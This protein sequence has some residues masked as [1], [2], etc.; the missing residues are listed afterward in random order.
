MRKV[1]GAAQKS[2]EKWGVEFYEKLYLYELDV[3]EKIL[4]RLTTPLAIF[5]SIAGGIL[6]MLRSYAKHGLNFPSVLFWVFFCISC[7][8]S[9]I[10]IFHLARAWWNNR[11]KIMPTAEKI[12]E[13]Y[14]DV[15]IPHYTPYPKH[16]ELANESF[17]S[18]LLDSYCEW[19]TIN[20]DT[21]AA[22][23]HRLFLANGFL[24]CSSILVLVTYGIFYYYSLDQG[25]V[26]ATQA[27]IQHTRVSDSVNFIFLDR[28]ID[29]PK[30]QYNETGRCIE[31]AK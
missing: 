17:S 2:D 21:N 10:S 24:I 14:S 6:F 3:R 18:Y 26:E 28:C 22:R 15:L 30:H 16:V 25:D 1:K 5:V 9:M 27:V 19:A 31:N 8:T 29:Q 20:A 11:Y 12:R 23:I 13:Y 4:G 7:L